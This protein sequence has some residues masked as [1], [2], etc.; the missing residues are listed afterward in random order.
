MRLGCGKYFAA[1]HGQQRLVGGDHMFAVGNGL[2][3]ELSGKG[4]AANDFD[5]HIDIGVVDDGKGVIHQ[6]HLVTHQAG[7][8]CQVAHSHHGDLHT[9]AG[10]GGND[11]GVALQ[12]LV[13]A[14]SHGAKA[15]HANAQRHCGQRE[16]GNG[17]HAVAAWTG[18]TSAMNLVHITLRTV[19]NPAAY[20]GL[21][22]EIHQ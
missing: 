18:K 16:R 17:Q 8:A 9:A 12:Y 10:S 4:G 6:F 15:Q 2:Q 11:L 21:F 20:A 19:A 5:H 22:R 7:G 14:D 13:G 1:M 3:H